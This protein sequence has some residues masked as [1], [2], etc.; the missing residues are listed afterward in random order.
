MRIDSAIL[1]NAIITASSENPIV[2]GSVQV[3]IA[4]TTGYSTFSSSIQTYTDA[5]VAGLVDS[6]PGTLNTLNELAAALGDDAN[7]S[8]SFATTLG[9]KLPTATHTAFSSSNASALRT[10]YSGADTTL[11]ASAH[12]DRIAKINVLSGSAHTQ[13]A[14]IDAKISALD[15]TYATDASVSSLSASAHTRRE[16]IS[17]SLQSTIDGL[18]ALGISTDT[19]RGALSSSAHTQREAIKGLATTANNSLSSS[20]AAALRTEYKAGDTALSA[21]AHTRRNELHALQLLSSSVGATINDNAVK[22]SGIESGATADQSNA[23]IRAAVEAASDSNV[24]TDADHSKLNAIEASADV[25]DATNVAAAG[26]LM[27]SSLGGT[28]NDNVVKLAGIEAGATADQTDEEIQDIV[29]AMVTGNTESGITVTYQDG[30]GT[31]DFSVASQTDENFTTADHAKLDGIEAGAD[32]TDTTN[33]TAAGALMDS[34][35]TSIADVKALDQSVVAGASPDFGT[36]NM[37]DASN[38]RFMTDA[39]ETKLDSVETNADV[40][41]ATNV[42]AA[43]ALMDSEVTN[44]AAVKAINQGLTTTS[45]VTFAD[46]LVT[47]NLTVQG[48]RTELQVATLNVED[49]NITVASGSADSAAADGAGITIAGADESLTWDH[50]NSRFNFSD[51]VHV[52][53]NITVSGNVDGRD[54]ATD[55]SKLDGIESGATADQTAAEIKTLVG[56]ASDSNV[57]TDALLSKLNAIEASADVTDATNVTAAGAVMDSEVTNLA[58]VKGLTKG[59][60]DGNV[61]TANDAVADNDFLRIDGTEVEGLSASEVRSAINVEDGATADQ[62]ASEIRTLLGTG[63]NGV[64]PSA[65]SAGQFLKHDGTFGTPSYT[66]N[67]DTVDMGDGF[68]VQN[69]GGSDQFTITENEGLRFAGAGATSVS[70]DSSTQKVT[71]TSTDNNTTYSVG[72][73]GLT[74][75]NFTDALK[76]K[77]DGIATGATANTGDITQVNIT[78]GTGLTGTVN[79]TSGNHVQT[80][81][82]SRPTSGDWWG[83]TA[84]VESDGVMEIGRYIDFHDSDSETDDYSVRLDGNGTT[85]AVSGHITSTGNITATGDVTAYSDETLK[86]D[87]K[88]IEGA[89]DKTKELRGVEFTRI[90]DDSKSIGVIAQELEKV[91]PELVS[92]DDEGIKSVNYAQITGL[93]IEAVKELSA[94]VEEL[95]K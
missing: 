91:L 46:I 42:T 68:K 56:N 54:V 1:T 7:M 36:A 81:D 22:L 18:D 49:L 9:T 65:G 25:T 84:Y 47:G 66:T 69:S 34:E 71:I 72:D 11:S 92:T 12:S 59:I 33:V 4:Q 13:R 23:E 77:L 61:L 5:K 80:I 29:G 20:T 28:I 73:G 67:T 8:A 41:D 16:Q 85:L 44:L 39:Q 63:N 30:D 74:E 15:S 62:T 90:A 70:F 3:N 76:T 35:L 88:T 89:L 64:I 38:K 58:F 27:S 83:H 79:T 26:A 2:S 6:A 52:V 94:K 78:A 24:F 86:K 93:L 55:G 60:S 19:E 21:S 95:S 75:N 87:V 40:T 48:T 37:T 32:V 51:D 14:A 17:A 57:F 53:G 82:I 10:E 50:G 45:D 31:I 43:G